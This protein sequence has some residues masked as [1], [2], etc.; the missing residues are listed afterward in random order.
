MNAKR[1]LAILLTLVLFAA[2]LTACGKSDDSK[3]SDESEN[4]TPTSTPTPE[5]TPTEAPKTPEEQDLAKIQEIFRAAEE[6]AADTT[7][8]V[9]E[10]ARFVLS[11][12]D[13]GIA[14]ELEITDNSYKRR[15]WENWIH[16]SGLTKA[17]YPLQ[18][19]TYKTTC[20]FGTITGVLDNAGKISWMADNL[21]P[22]LFTALEK[23]GVTTDPAYLERL[24][25]FEEIKGEWYGELSL[26]IKSLAKDFNLVGDTMGPDYYYKLIDFMKKYGFSGKVPVTNTVSFLSEKELTICLTYDWSGFINAMRKAGSTTDG[27]TK[28][29]ATAANV[30]ESALKAALKQQKTDVMTVGKQAMN[31]IE[32]MCKKASVE[33]YDGKYTYTGSIIKFN[34]QGDFSDQIT[35][36]REKNTMTITDSGLTMTLK[37]KQ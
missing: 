29:L 8:T 25:L 35:Y 16:N 17:S 14:F 24:A 19:E 1:L 27:M 4:V 6:T 20:T 5:P 7:Y 31:E 10:G 3:K 33:N 34:T 36:N 32:A 2:A 12:K 30:S 18:S 21:D 15:I 28:F 11:F 23:L 13:D 22:N 37:K 26:D 9:E